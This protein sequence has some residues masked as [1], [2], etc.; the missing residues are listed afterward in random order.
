MYLEY[1]LT[2]GQ[3]GQVHVYLSVESSCAQQCLVEHVGTV[4][5]CQYDDAA[6]GSESIHF[7]EQCVKSILTL[8]V[9]SHG[10]VLA[11]CASHGIDL[12]NEDD[13]R[14]FLLCLSEEVAHAACTH[15]DE[16]LYEVGTAHREE[17]YAC[18]AC[19]C[20]RQQGLSCSRR[21]YEQ[22]ALRYL[23][24]QV[25]VFLRFFEKLDNLLYLLFGGSLSGHILECYA[26]VVAL[27]V[28]ACLAFAHA[29][30]TSAGVASAHAAHEQYPQRDAKDER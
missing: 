27:L 21:T 8:V 5:C 4:G 30:H 19:H 25:G 10:G 20:L 22:C 18:L 13:A 29:E 2:L 15:A 9:A 26:Q 6:V 17:R 16:H 12:V 7:Y 24:S 11:S 28:H 23:S 14:R 3:V 1:L